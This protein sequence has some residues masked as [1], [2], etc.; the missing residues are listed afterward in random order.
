MTESEVPPSRDAQAEQHEEEATIVLAAIDTSTLSTRVVDLA[1]RI[2]RRTW[3]NARLHLL[4]VVRASR[5]DRPAQV[6]IDPDE[7]LGEANEYLD[8]YVRLARRQC[9]APVTG[10]LA[11]GDPVEQILQ[12]A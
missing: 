6:G 12:R 11:Q 7:V 1:A 5:I 9:P 10:H 2:T 4:H 3:Q 8:Y